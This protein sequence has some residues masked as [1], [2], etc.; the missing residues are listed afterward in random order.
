MFGFLGSRGLATRRLNS[1]KAL[2]EKEFGS[3]VT[4]RDSGTP[5][6]VLATVGSKGSMLG[7]ASK[8]KVRLIYL[9]AIH[10]PFPDPFEGSPLDDP[11]RTAQALLD[12][13]HRHGDAFLDGVL[14]LYTLVLIDSDKDRLVLACDPYGGPRVFI[15]ES[16]DGISFSTR[17]IDFVGLLD[18]DARLDRSLEDFLLGYEFLPEDRTMIAGVKALGRGKLASWEGSNHNERKLKGMALRPE[19]LE[20]AASKEEDAVV[21]AL[22]EAFMASVR[23]QCPSCGKIGVLQGGFDSMLIASV[24]TKMGREVETFTFRYKEKGHNQ[25]MVEDLERV[26]GIRHNWV[27]ITPRIME[28]GLAHFAE[29]FNQPVGQPHYLIASCE[30][31]RVMQQRSIEHCFTGDGCDGLFLGYPNVFARASFTQRLSAVRG[32]VAPFLRAAGASKRL[33]MLIGHPYRFLRNIG[34]VLMRPMPARGHI[35][36]CTLDQTSLKF[37]RKEKPEQEKKPDAVLENLA[38]GLE[39][40]SPVRLAYLGKGRVRLNSA[41]LEGI[42]RYSGITF[43]SPYLHPRMIAVAERI[44]DDL[45]RPRCSS[46]ADNAGK[47]IFRK[48]VDRHALLPARFV[49]QKKMS[50]VTSP[51]D[52]WFWG[53]LRE[54]ILSKVSALPFCMDQRYLHSLVT[55]KAAEI[56]FRNNIG[57]SRHVT[58]AA[59][60]LATYADFA[61]YLNR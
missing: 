25:E 49:H 47:Y 15:H 13:Y 1:T 18:A 45:N 28:E 19:L 57:I 46:K 2:I 58:Q 6:V 39:N 48:M 33:E 37:L 38:V 5:N 4:V 43:L 53:G 35:A 44:P 51:I 10:S 36:A 52:L 59:G 21:D 61:R 26:L 41:K 29:R 42:S 11:V 40:I 24:L 27:D 8:E 22:H 7:I 60:L 17:L 54:S 56:W 16:G 12:R 55:P 32:L 14:G 20:A 30:A 23:D 3:D 50:P 34:N 9:G 31:A